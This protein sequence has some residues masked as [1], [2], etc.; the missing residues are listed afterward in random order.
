MAAERYVRLAPYAPKQ[1]RFVQ[2]F[3]HKSYVFVGG[4]RPN[5][6]V[7]DAATAEELSTFTQIP[8]DPESKPMF[9]IMQK[10]KK[11]VIEKKETEQF[12]ASMGVVSATIPLP[13]DVEP[14]R[15]HDIRS[16]AIKD[17]EPEVDGRAEALPPPRKVVREETPA[18]SVSAP[19]EAEE[20]GGGAIT[21]QE[22]PEPTP[23][24]AAG[25]RR[26]K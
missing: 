5:W 3:C 11:D 25:R 15:T 1:G 7:V 23:K 21:T 12:L 6:Y 19:K 16:K 22:L 10:D 17:K 2:R 4:L 18:A 14:P 24:P 26:P 13:K 9:E 20:S 8:N